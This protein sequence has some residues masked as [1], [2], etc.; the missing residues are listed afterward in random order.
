[1]AA[2]ERSVRRDTN[3]RR[4]NRHPHR[5]AAS[6]DSYEH[7]GRGYSYPNG[8]I[9]T[10]WQSYPDGVWSADGERLY[11]WSGSISR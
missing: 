8:N 11:R 1:M 9:A 2:A 4:A 7:I 6:G 5:D 10:G 3:S